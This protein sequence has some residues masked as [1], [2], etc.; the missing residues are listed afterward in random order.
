MS[1]TIVRSVTVDDDS[2]AAIRGN[3]RY[4]FL[5]FLGASVEADD[6]DLQPWV[7]LVLSGSSSPRERWVAVCVGL[8]THPDFITY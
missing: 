1:D 5:R 6:E 8:A 2:E 4:L 3:L 7:D